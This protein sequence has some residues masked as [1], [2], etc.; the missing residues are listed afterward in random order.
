MAPRPQPGA[1]ASASAASA[2]P[3]G[4][5]VRAQPPAKAKA[6]ARRPGA[7]SPQRR[8]R[9]SDAPAA[10]AAAPALVAAEGEVQTAAVA[11]DVVADDDLAL[12]AVPG[13]RLRLRL[14]FGPLEPLCADLATAPN[15]YILLVPR[16]RTR[17]DG[18]YLLVDH[19]ARIEGC[20]L[21]GKP[22]ETYEFDHFLLANV[23]ASALPSL[24]VEHELQ[25][26]ETTLEP[27][28]CKRE[29]VGDG[30][31]LFGEADGAVT[32]SLEEHLAA[33]GDDVRHADHLRSLQAERGLRREEGEL[34]LT[35][36]KRLRRYLMMPE[37]GDVTSAC[38]LDSREEIAEE[39]ACQ[40]PSLIVK[41]GR[42]RGNERALHAA[43]V[44]CLRASG[45][46]A[47]LLLGLR[48]EAVEPAEGEETRW[49]FR[50]AL[51]SEFLAEGAGWVP[52]ERASSSD[53]LC[54]Q[55]P[56]LLLPWLSAT[57]SREEARS[58]SEV[59]R[60]ACASGDLDGV[61]TRIR[62]A[63]ERRGYAPGAALPAS[64]LTAVVAAA[65]GLEQQAAS[66]KVEEVLRF[67]ALASRGES[68]K[69]AA[70]TE[71]YGAIA[72]GGC[73]VNLGFGIG[74]CAAGFAGA[75]LFEG[76]PYEQGVPL[77]VSELRQAWLALPDSAASR[78]P[79]GAC[80]VAFRLT[81]ELEEL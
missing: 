68:E 19:H 2:R 57:P 6:Q 74:P 16:P 72:L 32:L 56:S 53:A 34:A 62:R 29:S 7:P 17:V 63:C 80:R 54:H 65:L 50:E 55:A 48:C 25:L 26:Q 36:A 4:S 1:A 70:F 58:T 67:C 64:D 59:M 69:A 43:F 30:S 13:K 5:G 9:Q 14:R 76:G 47:R 77:D 79:A 61:L 49:R 45:V 15:H 41:T 75:A 42:G 52:W 27:R 18:H 10:D 40:L 46:P 39:D 35:F 12:R 60:S 24:C 33:L 20:T 44:Y 71:G 73:P 38:A 3:G 21:R 66:T 28:S 23:P 81:C 51:S 31:G 22:V 78:P 8:Q 11:Q 37:E